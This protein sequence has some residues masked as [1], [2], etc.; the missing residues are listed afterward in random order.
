MKLYNLGKVPWPESQMIY[1]IGSVNDP[2]LRIS[3]PPDALEAQGP[4]MSLGVLFIQV[5]NF[6]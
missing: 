6:K 2:V 1:H 5:P 4:S 3:V